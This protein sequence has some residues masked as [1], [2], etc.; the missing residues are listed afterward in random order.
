MIPQN[1]PQKRKMTGE[2]WTRTTGE[3][4]LYTYRTETKL[5]IKAKESS[6]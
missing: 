2:T 4:Y 6:I 1:M 3:H 5:G